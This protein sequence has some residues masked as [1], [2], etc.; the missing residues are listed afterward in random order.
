VLG[1]AAGPVVIDS[2]ASLDV[3]F[4]GFLEALESLRS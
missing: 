1:C 2:D 4:P 3:S